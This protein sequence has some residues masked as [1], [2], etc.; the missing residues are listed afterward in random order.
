MRYPHSA[1]NGLANQDLAPTQIKG[2]KQ[3]RKR[4]RPTPRT[5][6]VAVD[7]ILAVL[8]SNLLRQKD[9]S[10]FRGTVG[11]CTRFQAHQAQHGGRVNDPSSVT[12]G[13]KILRQELR[14]SIFA[15]KKDGAGIDLPGEEGRNE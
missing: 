2:T 1:A 8:N 12:R 13:M 9:H 3:I 11:S 5:K 10:S 14:D 6:C 4:Q 7:F 15:A